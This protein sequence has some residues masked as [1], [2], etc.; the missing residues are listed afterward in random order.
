LIDS[1]AF[2]WWGAGSSALGPAARNAIADPA[3]NGLV[4]IATVWELAIKS[5]LGKL[6]LPDDL[7]TMVMAQGFSVLPI[8][9]HHIRR[10][11]VLPLHHRDPFDRMLIA[12]ALTEGIPVATVDNRF[13]AYGVQ[14]V[15]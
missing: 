12:Q 14:I 5:S 2:L 4:S 7:E 3:N 15:W 11:G 10:A 1:H 9:F 13:A 8:A 6:P